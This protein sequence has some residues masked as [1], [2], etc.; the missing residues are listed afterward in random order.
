MGII[1]DGIATPSE[2]SGVGVFGAAIAAIARGNYNW[3]V[4]FD[5]C[6]QLVF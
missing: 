4:I 5:A 1:L 6:K 3:K 2:A